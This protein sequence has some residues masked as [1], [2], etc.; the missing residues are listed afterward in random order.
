MVQSKETGDK[1]QKREEIIRA[2]QHRFGIY[3]IKKTSMTEIAH[4]L[5]MSK[6]LLYYYF[7]DKAHIYKSVVEK[8]ILEF[9]NKVTAEMRKHKNPSEQLMKYVRLRVT[10]FRSLLNLSQLRLEEMQGFSSLME[11]ILKSVR[12]FEKGVIIDILK[13]GNNSGLFSI[14]DPEEIA[15]LLL[16]TLRG[17]RIARIRDKKLF[18]LDQE[19]YDFLMRR[20]EVLMELLIHGLISEKKN[21]I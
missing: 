14:K 17:I 16:D 15:E 20:S 19:E 10:Y 3:G 5:N 21:S 12:E 1:I 4:D 18:Y 8:E 7:P 6:G 2:A 13:R 9:E 11:D